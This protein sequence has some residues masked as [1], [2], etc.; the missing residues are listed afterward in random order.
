M[1][2]I[3]TGLLPEHD[4]VET[5]VFGPLRLTIPAREALERGGNR[6]ALGACTYIADERRTDLPPSARPRTGV[7]QYAV[8][9]CGTVPGDLLL[10]AIAAGGA[11][12]AECGLRLADEPPYQGEWPD[13]VIGWYERADW[14]P[15]P[16]PDCGRALMRYEAG[17]VPGYRV[18]VG[19]EHHHVQVSADGRR[20]KA[21]TT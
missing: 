1:S 20:A 11:G 5:P 6:V 19:G 16:V 9:L 13:Q 18:C 8:T 17:Y 15:C 7:A 4:A 12:E 3:R 14:L 10:C 2:A 21:V